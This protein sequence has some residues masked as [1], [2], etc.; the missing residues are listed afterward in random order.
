M[1]SF[2]YVVKGFSFMGRGFWSADVKEQ[3]ATLAAEGKSF[4]EI[5]KITTVP[6]QTIA[7]W[8]IQTQ[9]PVLELPAARM[10]QAG[11]HFTDEDKETVML[12]VLVHRMGAAAIAAHFNC[13]TS[14][15]YNLKTSQDPV[16]LRL[17][18]QH[19]REILDAIYSG[20]P[21]MI[22]RTVRAPIGDAMQ[23]AIA[24]EKLTNAVIMLE[25][26]ANMVTAENGKK[27]IA[28][29][30]RAWREH[31]ANQPQRIGAEIVESVARPKLPERP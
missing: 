9:Q 11:E 19:Q 2:H 16:V 4:R 12:M 5:E 13:S 14:T 1:L 21:S 31:V 6:H 22:E 17:R 28:D 3:C 18:A 10:R 27:T 8:G 30:L 25:N 24:V 20:L 7:S 29:L 15:I 26:G 23:G